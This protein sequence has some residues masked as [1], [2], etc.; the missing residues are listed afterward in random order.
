MLNTPT[1]RLLIVTTLL[2]F[3]LIAGCGDETPS[4]EPAG[5][6]GGDNDQ[7]YLDEYG[8]V[9]PF[10]PLVTGGK[11]DSTSSGP[12]VAWEQTDTVWRISHQWTDV[13]P[14]AGLAWE[15]DSGLSWEEKYGAW[16]DSLPTQ[17]RT[18]S[19]TTF[20]VTTPYG[21]E[22]PAPILECAEVAMF[23][24]ITFASW[25]GLPFYMTASYQGSAIYLGH[26]GFRKADGSRFGQTPNFKSR[27]KDYTGQWDGQSAFPS[28]ASLRSKGLYGGG[29]EVP[30]LPEVDGAPAKAGA[31]FDALF[32][33]K[34][35][36]HLMMLA[37]PW[38]GSINLASDSN[39]Y[40]IQPEATRA[41]D[42][43]LH[44]WQRQGIGH[45]MPVMRSRW[46]TESTLEL[47]IASGSMPRRQPVWEE[48]ASV[49]WYF[50]SEDG[51]GEGVNNDGDA[52]VELGGGIRRWRAPVPRNGRYLNSSTDDTV[53]IPASNKAALAARPGRFAQLLRVASAEELRDA[54]LGRVQ[55][56]RSHLAE[57]P[58]SCSARE[59]REQAFDT[60]YEVMSSQFGW[61]KA[62][63]DTTYRT[64]GDYVFAEL[65]YNRSR[66]CCWN[67]T[68][69]AMHEI[70]MAYAQREQQQAADQSVC[71]EPTV[72]K[73][74]DAGGVGEDGFGRWR[75]FA[76]ELG[77]GADWRAWSEDES[78]GQRG[79]VNDTEAEHAQVAF[80]DLPSVSDEP[81]PI[82]ACADGNDTRPEASDL[83]GAEVRGEICGADD[84]DFHRLVVD[85]ARV[86][87][88]TLSFRHADGDLD[89]LLQDENGQQ[90]AASQSTADV[91]RIEQR[92]TA[93]T[94][95]VKVYG[96]SG[97]TGAYTL[98]ADTGDA[99]DT[100]SCQAGG[101][102]PE[103][104]VPIEA[105]SRQGLKICAGGS[106]YFSYV[107]TSDRVVSVSVTFT[108]SAGDLD[109]AVSHDGEQLGLS[110]STN[111]GESVSVAAR[112]GEQILIRVY[113]YAGASNTY[114]LT[115]A[116]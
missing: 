48:G 25:Y 64:L 79:V 90:V 36:G 61:T 103:A 116:E 46:S 66:S 98:T 27:Y 51:G 20:T 59:R 16:V 60:L 33:N 26:F 69:G 89:L 92:L 114:D 9:G 49:L 42:V 22:L 2:A 3:G 53:F 72:F 97:A 110:D 78:C 77:R 102:S 65:V 23:L 8:V 21:V 41:G 70:I 101:A 115:I 32:L 95:Y 30:F 38:F 37:L 50:T 24:R 54:A 111:N 71:L 62:E 55:A 14:E 68:T 85:T 76:G 4:P 56:A 29:D 84:V 74:E 40:H 39:M 10:E 81:E 100:T 19:G 1:L 43:L 47:A 11:E 15:A 7:A 45:T 104:A 31:Y 94:W 88:V 83:G 105:G 28:D 52:Y 12:S 35:T 109:L 44:R 96:W 80:C 58:S 91:E 113:G 107:S 17:A 86:V 67:S 112:R 34:R 73:G 87:T 108:H 93:G 18:P 82:T 106:H 63:V 99:V 6:A 57:H 5:P 13:T 75:V